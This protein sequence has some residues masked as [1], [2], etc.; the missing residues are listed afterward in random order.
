VRLRAVGVTFV[1]ALTVASPAAATSSPLT[2]LLRLKDLPAGFRV[3]TRPH[4]ILVGP[5]YFGVNLSRYG[6][7][8]AA[9]VEFADYAAQAGALA[10]VDSTVIVFRTAKSAH[11]GYR[12]LLAHDRLGMNTSFTVRIGQ[13]SAGTG[14]DFPGSSG[15]DIYWRYKNI[16]AIVDGLYVLGEPTRASIL[17]PIAQREQRRLIASSG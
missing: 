14:A 15:R 6:A 3:A 5:S 8:S 17:V 4:P 12:A 9:G 7:K 10:N 2:L 13:E 16:V 11:A 1:L